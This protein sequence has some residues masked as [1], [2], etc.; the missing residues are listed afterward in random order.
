M[1]YNPRVNGAVAAAT[2]GRRHRAAVERHAR[3]GLPGHHAAAEPV[4][5]PASRAWTS[6]CSRQRA[7]GEFARVSSAAHAMR[8][9]RATRKKGADPRLG[10]WD[11]PCD[12]GGGGLCRWRTRSPARAG[13]T[14]ELERM[15]D[16]ATAA[17]MLA[18]PS[19]IGVFEQIH[20]I[21]DILHAKGALLYMDGANMNALVTR[22]AR[23]TALRRGRHALE[24]AQNVL[25]S[26]RRRRARDR[27]RWGQGNSGA[28]SAEAGAGGAG[29]WRAGA[30][31]STSR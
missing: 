6:R 10:A 2:G 11:K 4:P 1:K 23:P 17:L 16:E 9:R 25:H 27:G 19:T 18:N 24:P 5:D 21:A 12:G 14:G 13:G 15:V 20:K 29:G 31:V 30:G 22:T 7:R 28:V 26:A 3:A 8:R